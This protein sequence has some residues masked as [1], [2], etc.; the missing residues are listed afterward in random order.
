V[1][2]GDDLLAGL[3]ALVAAGAWALAFY[4]AFWA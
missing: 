4:L 3:V 1:T 2:R